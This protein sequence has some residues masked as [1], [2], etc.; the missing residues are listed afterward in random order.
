MRMNIVKTN[1][2]ANINLYIFVYTILANSGVRMKIFH[3]WICN[4]DLQ[5]ST[6]TRHSHFV[7]HFSFLSC[8]YRRIS[9]SPYFISS[10]LYMKCWECNAHI[11]NV[12]SRI[13]YMKRE[14]TFCCKKKMDGMKLSEF[15]PG[16]FIPFFSH[17]KFVSLFSYYFRVLYSS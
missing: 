16:W 5:H 2:D 8:T 9:W 15:F 14:T 4:T 6:K 1:T 11:I 13:K 17:N 3:R 12:L 10:D 7:F